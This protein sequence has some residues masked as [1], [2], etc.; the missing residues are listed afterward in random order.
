MLWDVHLHVKKPQ[1]HVHRELT[2]LTNLAKPPISAAHC[3]S[4]ISVFSY[5]CLRGGRPA[6]HTKRISQEQTCHSLLGLNAGTKTFPFYIVSFFLISKTCSFIFLCFPLVLFLFFGAKS[7][8]DSLLPLDFPAVACRMRAASESKIR[9]SIVV[10]DDL[11]IRWASELRRRGR[12]CEAA[13]LRSWVA[14][15]WHRQEIFEHLQ[16]RIY[17][18]SLNSKKILYISWIL[19]PLW[20]WE[21]LVK[22][23]SLLL[24]LYRDAQAWHTYRSTTSRKGGMALFQGVGGCHVDSWGM[25]HIERSIGSLEVMMNYSVMPCARLL[26]EHERLKQICGL[27]I[28]MCVHVC[29]LCMIHPTKAMTIKDVLIYKHHQ[30]LNVS[31]WV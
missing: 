21:S 18:L 29:I 31:K 8:N 12:S 20:R 2:Q 30:P 24:A 28:R 13:K 6:G 1:S 4:T 25:V 9:R 14:G 19:T 5:N 3:C 15:P 26:I 10:R 17:S 16:G 27:Q 7:I 23:R 11:D 22:E